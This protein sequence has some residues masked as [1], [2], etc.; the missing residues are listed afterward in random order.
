MV[1]LEILAAPERNPVVQHLSGFTALNGGPHFRFN[2]AVSF[3]VHC[4]DQKE[5]DYYWEKLTA[6]ERAFGAMMQMKKVDIA[7]LRR[8]YDGK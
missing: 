5:V 3:T 7:A 8:A 2:E 6:A 4:A 1:L